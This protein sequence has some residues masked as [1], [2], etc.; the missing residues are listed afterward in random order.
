MRDDRARRVSIALIVVAQSTQGLAF[1]G[2]ALF[3][4]L[5]RDD[6]AMTFSQAGSLAV[7]ASLIYS[8][9]Q[10]PSGYL[11]DRFGAKRL[12]LLGLLGLNAV[13]LLLAVID[14]YELLVVNQLVS[15]FFRSL[16]FAPG[17]VLI[18]AHF[19]PDRRASAM[20]LYIAGGFSSNIV[21]N[22]LGP[23][24]VDPLGWRALFVI[25]S[26]AGIGFSLLYWKIGGPGPVPHS[27]ANRPRVRELVRLLRYRV[28]WLTGVVQFVRL[29]V[30]QGLRFW[31]PSYI[32]LEKGFPLEI[33]G[34]VVAIGSAVTAPSNYVG[35]YI[36]DRLQRP[37]LIVGTSLSVLAVTFVLLVVAD[38]LLVIIAVVA[39]QS[40]FIQA[41]FGP[42]FEIPLRE[43]GSKAAGT[44]TGFGNFWA[45]IGAL[46]FSY[47]IGVS[48]DQTGSF[49]LG[50]Y[51]LG[52]ACLVA[53]VATVAL[54][55]L[56][57]VVRPR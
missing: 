41:Y 27:K 3:L 29:G 4:P 32:V 5:I 36:S 42:L 57:P 8:F 50:F 20:G 18:T 26:A 37:L 7:A 13:S 22:L 35:G 23:V 48:K 34:L 44:V 10:I 6:I 38:D 33:A 1:G 16:V 56:A 39:V 12:F 45:N 51:S 21:L 28:M 19:R 49:D 31:L 55:R 46:V 52:A 17:L 53:L 11:A 9:M 15:G 25:F 24:L 47:L 30:T 43:L 54:T 2:I 14:T 40:L